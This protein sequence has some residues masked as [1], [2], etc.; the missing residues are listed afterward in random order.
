MEEVAWSGNSSS[1]SGRTMKD[2]VLDNR[3][4][5]KPTSELDP[6]SWTIGTARYKP[7][8]IIMPTEI[9]NVKT[10]S[11]SSVE[12]SP[13]DVVSRQ[14]SIRSASTNSLGRSTT[15]STNASNIR[16]DSG[17][18][19]RRRGSSRSSS[20]HS[21][22]ARDIPSGD[23]TIPSVPKSLT[24]RPSTARVITANRIANLHHRPTNNNVENVLALHERSTKLFSMTPSTI[25]TA[26]QP[27]SRRTS[28]DQSR[29]SHQGYQLARSITSPNYHP[30]YLSSSLPTSP[31][32][33]LSSPP[34]QF[35]SRPHRPSHRIR[36]HTMPSTSTTHHH[37]PPTRSHTAT[38]SPTTPTHFDHHD[39]PFV[40]ATVMHWTSDE[41]RRREYAAIDKQSRGLRGLW[42]KLRPK[43]LRSKSGSNSGFWDEVEGDDESDAGSVR[44]Y[45][46]AIDEDD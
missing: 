20:K 37:R 10:L 22:P 30:D 46:L 24:I 4:T 5:V 14:Q 6:S 23:D 7:T 34:P 38:T 3:Q 21:I 2:K 13:N 27:N 39:A 41:T 18:S 45:R 40:P 16:R 32:P 26:T 25:G 36:T 12:S 35:N 11:I 42:N 19:S 15:N 17:Y 1:S 43:M 44:R 29:P 8:E 31:M 33:F 9:L 28:V